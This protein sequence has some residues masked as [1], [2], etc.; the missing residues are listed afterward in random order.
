MFALVQSFLYFSI[1]LVSNYADYTM[2]VTLT[3]LG[4]LGFLVWQPASQR[5]R[6]FNPAILHWYVYTGDSLS[7]YLQYFVI[8]VAMMCVTCVLCSLN[9]SIGPY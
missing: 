6:I 2:P 7:K 8:L 3:L 4:T 1:A 5:S 9:I